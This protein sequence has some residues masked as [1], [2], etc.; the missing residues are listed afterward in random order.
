MKK[1]GEQLTLFDKGPRRDPMRHHPDNWLASTDHDGP[2]VYHATDAQ[3]LP[4]RDRG[5]GAHVD[6]SGSSTG[7]HF[8]TEA[9]ARDRVYGTQDREWIHTARIADSDISA[10]HYTDQEA[11]HSPVADAAVQVGKAVA[12]TNE[13]ED[14]GSISYRAAP[15][16]VSTWGETVMRDKFAHPAL[17]HLASRGYNPAINLAA[18]KEAH[19]TAPT[20]K[21]LFGGSAPIQDE[22]F[23]PTLHK[24]G[25][26]F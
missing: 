9:A 3:H 11:N 1:V 16:T 25:L 10:G 18:E 24:T 17:K 22:Q 5:S 21:N 20:Q 12:Y 13:T 23:K 7:M 2:V 6:Y 4:G 8:G 19:W 14:P 26:R 15:D